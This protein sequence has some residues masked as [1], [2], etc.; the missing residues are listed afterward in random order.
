MRLC[1][2]TCWEDEY[3]RR[4]AGL[5]TDDATVYEVF[6]ALARS[7]S[8]SGR[9]AA[10]VPDVSIELAEQHVALAH[11]LGLRFNYLMNGSCLGGVEFS[12]AGRESL[13]AQIRWV[14]RVGA[15]A[16][17]VATPFLVQLARAIA[18]RLEIV[19]STIAHVDSVAAARIYRDLGAHRITVSL[20]INRDLSLLRTLASEASC[21]LEL[22]ANEMCLYRCPFRAYHFDLMAHGSQLADRGPATEYPHLLCSARRMLHPAELLK[23]RFIR[24]EDVSA[25]ERCGID[26]IKVAGRGHDAATLLRAAEAYLKRRFDG[27]LLDL[28]DLGLYRAP[29]VAPPALYLDNRALDGFLEAVAGIDCARACGVSCTHCDAL[30]ASAVTMSGRKAYASALAQAGPALVRGTDR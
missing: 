21:E 30:A 4:L 25:Y 23:A 17:T 16:V 24:P 27:N 2:A 6:G 20:M 15:D 9:D 19:V 29:G 26:L 5:R 13:V 11:T 3:L 12:R 1:V 10:I 7:A 14:D 22:L 18:P 8:G 28:T